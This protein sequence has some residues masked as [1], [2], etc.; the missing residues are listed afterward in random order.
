MFRHRRSDPNHTS[1]Y[2]GGCGNGK[3]EFIPSS[4]WEVHADRGCHVFKA[5]MYAQN[6]M[7]ID[8]VWP[9]DPSAKATATVTL[10]RLSGYEPST[11]IQETIYAID[12]PVHERCTI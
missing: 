2:A 6:A 8:F 9:F 5:G 10:K 3:D 11:A 12:I 1:G 7:I 4:G